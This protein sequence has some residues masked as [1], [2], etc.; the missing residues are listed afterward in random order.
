[1]AKAYVNEAYKKV[2]LIGHQIFGGTG[3][4]VEH[5]MPIYSR[6]AKAAEY[7]FGNTSYHRNLVASELNL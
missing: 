3:Y 6:R 1:V 4:I 7:A 5:E 2:A